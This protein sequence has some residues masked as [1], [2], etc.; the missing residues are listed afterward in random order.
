MAKAPATKFMDIS[1]S[2]LPFT[3]PSERSTKE[4]QMENGKLKAQGPE[5]ADRQQDRLVGKSVKQSGTGSS[6][7]C[8]P[9]NQNC[10]MIDRFL[11]HF[12]AVSF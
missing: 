1:A 3:L 9:C 7:I 4:I 10:R 8:V 11:F 6:P 2:E 5:E 12:L